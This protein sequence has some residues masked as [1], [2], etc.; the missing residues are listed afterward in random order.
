MKTMSRLRIQATCF[1]SS[2]SLTTLPLMRSSVS[3]E[4]EVS[5]SEESVDIEAESTMTTRMPSRRSGKFETR[6]GMMES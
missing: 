1:F 2:I 5:T 6:A 4:D 3:V